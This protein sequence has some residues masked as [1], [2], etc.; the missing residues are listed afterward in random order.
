MASWKLFS[1]L[2]F[3]LFQHKQYAFWKER[4]RGGGVITRQL[5]TAS[6]IS[7]LE[8]SFQGQVFNT[9]DHT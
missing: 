5:M 9:K 8:V 1:G 6:V 4:L 2:D 7:D 3:F